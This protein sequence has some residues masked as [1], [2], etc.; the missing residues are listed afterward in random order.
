MHIL[1]ETLD[2]NCIHVYRKHWKQNTATYF[3]SSSCI[4][5]LWWRHDVKET[6]STTSSPKELCKN[7]KISQY[8]LLI[9][10][11]NYAHDIKCITDDAVTLSMTWVPQWRHAWSIYPTKI[12]SCIIATLY[13]CPRCCQYRLTSVSAN[14]EASVC[15]TSHIAQHEP[16]T[17]ALAMFMA[18]LGAVGKLRDTIEYYTIFRLSS[19]R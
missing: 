13:L 3:I 16:Y 2:A 6:A 17:N 8:W 1:C 4:S 11:A 12:Y 7:S 14:E 5:L 10:P 15:C 9:I 19:T 18:A